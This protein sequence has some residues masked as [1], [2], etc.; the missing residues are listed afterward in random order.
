[1]FPSLP[2]FPKFTRCGTCYSEMARQ[3]VL[4]QTN[5]H[6]LMVFRF[7]PKPQKFSVRVKATA[8]IHGSL[9]S[10]SFPWRGAKPSLPLC[11]CTHL[12]I[13]HGLFS[14]AAACL[15]RGLCSY[16]P[17]SRWVHRKER[18]QEQNYTLERKML[19]KVCCITFWCRIK[20]KNSRYEMTETFFEECRE[21]GLK[22]AHAT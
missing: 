12:T 18:E 1:M 3:Q 14:L 17:H 16:K 20:H 11:T 10:W 7:F 5:T 9:T 21:F 19:V 13:S 6:I 22:V 15:Q 8:E 4:W 2:C